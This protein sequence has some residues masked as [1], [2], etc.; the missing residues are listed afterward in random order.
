[1]IIQWYGQFCF[2]LTS[3]DLV[4][5]IDPFAKDIGLTP[6]RFRADLA[7]VTHAHFDHANT[8]AIA[9]DPF[10][11][12]NA[13][14]YEVKGV[15]VRGIQTFHDE[16]E[17]VERGANTVYKIT[18]EGLSLVHMGDFGERELRN[19]TLEAIGETDILL[20]P[21]GG[22]YTIDAAAAAKI[23]KQIEPAIAIPMHYKLPGLKVHLEGIEQFLKEAGATKTEAQDKL[24]IKKK[25]LAERNGKT[26][27]V[28][29][30]TANA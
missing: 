7:L 14:E 4:I 18:Y 24:T 1:M 2:K 22:T 9:G 20:L 30:K 3:G 17:G 21:V 19:E 6:P 26:E 27:I 12:T 16:T 15:S 5:A 13:G 11:I 29:L 10:I 8:D 25:D 23:I 28:V